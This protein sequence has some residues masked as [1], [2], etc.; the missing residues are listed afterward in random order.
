MG[1]GDGVAVADRQ[2]AEEGLTRSGGRAGGGIDEGSECGKSMLD[3]TPAP[4]Q[5]WRR[6]GT[7]RQ[8]DRLAD[9]QRERDRETD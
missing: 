8:T 9:R 4:S 1:V 7:D 2:T 3:A 5:R 6:L